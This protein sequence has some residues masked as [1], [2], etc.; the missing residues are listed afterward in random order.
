MD[1]IQ[2]LSDWP[3][4]LADFIESR[5]HAAFE[6]GRNDC[7]TF[8]ADALQAMTGVD[9][10][11]QLRGQWSE[12]DQALAIASRLHGLPMAA[13]RLLGRP[14]PSAA[15]APRGAVVCARMGALPIM[16]VLT[17]GR[18]CAPG[19]DGLQFRPGTEVRLAWGY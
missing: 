7:V 11:A 10:L 5:R 4:R 12:Q 6:W 14:L 19:A 13:R 8:A 15:M 9:V 1:Q 17:D 2:R 3:E 16:G 18:W